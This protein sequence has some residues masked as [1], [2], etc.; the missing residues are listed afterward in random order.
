MLT[1]LVCHAACCYKRV[2]IAQLAKLACRTLRHDAR[3]AAA[4]SRRA[5]SARCALSALMRATP[6]RV[7]RQQRAL[8]CLWMLRRDA[9]MRGIAMLIC[10]DIAPLPPMLAAARF[11]MMRT[12]AI[13]C[14]P[15]A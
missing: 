5:M 4:V 2:M 10:H 15:R 8:L 3:A 6:Q 1:L 14:L 9:A 12:I 11:D 7:A 13:F